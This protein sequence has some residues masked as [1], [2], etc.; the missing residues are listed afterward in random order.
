VNTRKDE[1]DLKKLVS[2]AIK[3]AELIKKR[4]NTSQR[5]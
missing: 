4:Q 5:K 2:A 3:K 1:D